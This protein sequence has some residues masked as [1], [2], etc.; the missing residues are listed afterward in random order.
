MSTRTKH[1][2]MVAC[3]QRLILLSDLTDEEMKAGGRLL[4]VA[5]DTSGSQF[6]DPVQAEA[7]KMLAEYNHLKKV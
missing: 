1:A 5:V 7:E 3:T 2:R 6:A 4:W